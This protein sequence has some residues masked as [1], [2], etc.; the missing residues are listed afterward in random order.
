MFAGIGEQLPLATGISAEKVDKLQE[1]VDTLAGFIDVGYPVKVRVVD[2]DTINAFA[3]PGGSIVVF[4]GLLNKIKSENGLAFILAHE[5][6]HF[7][8]RDHLRGMGRG[9]VLAVISTI[10][11]GA[12]SGVS[13]M[14]A[15]TSAF[16]MAQYSQ[17]RESAADDSALAAL[18][19]CYGHVGGATDL[20]EV[21]RADGIGEDSSTLSGYFAS[22]PQVQKRIADLKKLAGERG[23]SFG[24]VRSISFQVKSKNK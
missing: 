19:C 14:L 7:K 8:N 12:D 22:H 1:L 11:T 6:A 20:F 10:I 5:L 4:S 2:S 24:A 23:Y 15:P 16:G 18:A 3:F 21:L 13:R 9:I 17:K